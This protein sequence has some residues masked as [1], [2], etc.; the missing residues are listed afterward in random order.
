MAQWGP[1][2]THGCDGDVVCDEMEAWTAAD[3]GG[4]IHQDGAAMVMVP[5]AP[6]CDKGALI[7][8]CWKVRAHGAPASSV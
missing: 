3:S 8:F 7:L 4:P 5:G 2:C 6:E 1:K